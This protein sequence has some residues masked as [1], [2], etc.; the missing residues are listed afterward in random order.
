[1]PRNSCIPENGLALLAGHQPIKENECWG[2]GDPNDGEDCQDGLCADCRADFD[3]SD[4]EDQL[5]TL[6]TLP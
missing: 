4:L 5:E 2:C 3:E 1:M 6:M